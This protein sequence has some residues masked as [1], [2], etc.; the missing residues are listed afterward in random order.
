[1]DLASSAARL[2]EAAQMDE[3]EV[4]EDVQW[5]T[6]EPGFENQCAICEKTIGAEVTDQRARWVIHNQVSGWASWMKVCG[7]CTKERWRSMNRSYDHDEDYR[8]PHVIKPG[9]EQ[10]HTR[11]FEMLGRKAVQKYGAMSEFVDASTFHLGRYCSGI[12]ENE[13]EEAVNAPVPMDDDLEDKA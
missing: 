6:D 8:L 2:A 11:I 12:D 10:W 5:P 7:V 9:H 4:E 1:M 3:M 13:F